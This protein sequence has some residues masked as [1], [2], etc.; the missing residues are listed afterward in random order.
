MGSMDGGLGW[1]WREWQG[2]PYLRCGLLEGWDHGF[3]TQQCWP[4]TPLGLVEALHPG[5]SVYRTHQVHGNRVFGVAELAPIGSDEGRDGLAQGDGSVTMM[6][7]Q[8]VWACSADCTPA[9][10]ADRRSGQVAAVH[11]GWRGTSLRIVPVAIERLLAQGSQ[12]ADLVVAMGPAIDGSVYQVANSVAADVGASLLPELAA[13][14]RLVALE[15]L[16]RSPILPDDK[17]GHVRLDVRRINEL[18]LLELGLLP[19]QIAIAPFCTY[20]D[21]VNFFSYRRNPEKKVQWSGIV[22]R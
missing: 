6:A 15:T 10:I 2:L 20:Q 11:A 8:S 1:S 22:S 9:L 14:E 18:Q 5:A 17:P 3:F 7:G 13:E 16:E 12:L 4:R 21:P 19:E